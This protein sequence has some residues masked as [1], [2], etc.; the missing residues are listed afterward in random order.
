MNSGNQSLNSQ[1]STMND[2][3]LQSIDSYNY[4][5]HNGFI[6]N[7]YKLG[8]IRDVNEINPISLTNQMNQI[9]KSNQLQRKQ[10]S[11]AHVQRNITQV[12]NYTYKKFNW[13]K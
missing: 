5:F 8:S 2:T 10:A 6:H 9:N 13:K 1:F 7:P 11:N 12:M 3:Q 4:N